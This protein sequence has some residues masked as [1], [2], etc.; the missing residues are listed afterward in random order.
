MQIGIDSRGIRD[1]FKG[2]VGEYTQELLAGFADHS[3]HRYE[4]LSSGFRTPQGPLPAGMKDTRIDLPNKYLNARLKLTRGPELDTYFSLRPDVV[5]MPNLNL[6]HVQEDVPLV[7]TVHDL[8]FEIYPEVFSQRMQLWHKWIEPKRLLQ[9]ADHIIAVSHST[10]QDI[11]DLYGIPAKN[12]SVTHLGVSDTFFADHSQEYSTVRER[13][14]LP[15]K[16]ILYLGTI[17]PRKNIA[18]LVSAFEQIA[19]SH[20]EHHLVIAGKDGWLCEDIHRAINTSPVSEKIHSIGFV[21]SA[22]K[23]ALYAM[24]ELFVYPSLYEGFGFPP[25]EAM[26]SGTATITSQVSS[27]PELVKE[28]AWKVSP[29]DINDITES[30]HWL[31]KKPD[32]RSQYQELGRKRARLFRWNDT[33]QQTLEILKN[34]APNTT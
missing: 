25:L 32:I 11:Q 19:A 12:I 20:P 23:P 18:R 27:L 5:F 33:V 16:Y 14:H 21:E 1:G 13:Y 26:A 7:V 29:Y 2:G 3:E 31:L 15:E 28:S 9:R 8:S 34:S 6:S 30:M 4:V 10:K 17:E 22:H 24:A